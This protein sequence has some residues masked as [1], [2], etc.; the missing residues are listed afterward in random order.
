MRRCGCTGRDGPLSMA[1][2]WRIAWICAARVGAALKDAMRARDAVRLSTLR[3]IH[4]AIKDRDIDLRGE[5]RDEGASDA[6]VLAILARMVK[7]RQESA[8]LYEEGGRLDMAE[9][10]ARGDRGD[11]GVPA[12]SARRG[13]GLGRDRR[14]G[15][16]DLGLGR[17]RHGPASWRR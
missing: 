17:A 15:G 12:A 11:R 1:A 16:R 4:A 14:G 6:D 8:R 7:Q 2:Q 13:R 3:L 9:E 10:E 5:G